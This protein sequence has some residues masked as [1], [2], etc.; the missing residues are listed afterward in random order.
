MGNCPAIMFSP[1]VYN[2]VILPVDLWFR[3]QF[4][5]F[6]IHH[7]GKIDNYLQLYTALSPDGFDI[8]GGSNYKLLRQYY[9][10]ATNSYIVNPE[11]FE[12]MSTEVIDKLIHGIVTDG[13]PIN[14]ISYLHTYGVGRSAT[15]D[16]VHDLRTSIV[17]QSLNI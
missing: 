3:Q 15:D 9:P 11:H 7:C 2:E 13:G 1:E 4:K 6:N 12:G 14:Y 8:G 5:K 17:R 10:T 16:N